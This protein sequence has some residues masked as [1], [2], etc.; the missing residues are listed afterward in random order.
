MQ[1][2]ALTQEERKSSHGN[3]KS[4]APTVR[5][6]QHPDLWHD[7][8]SLFSLIL[9]LFRSIFCLF[10]FWC[11]CGREILALF[12]FVVIFGHGESFRALCRHFRSCEITGAL[13]LGIYWGI[14]VCLICR[15]NRFWIWPVFEYSS[16]REETLMCGELLGS[17]K[18]QTFETFEPTGSQ[19]FPRKKT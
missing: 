10:L 15:L 9:F 6:P 13:I 16:R 7:S 1:G 18:P 14:F 2:S 3:Q 5:D 12:F 4:F 17:W 8:F 19:V 11:F